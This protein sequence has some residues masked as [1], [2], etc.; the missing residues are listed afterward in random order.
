MAERERK[1]SAIP[2]GAKARVDSGFVAAR[3]KPC[4]YTRPDAK[5]FSANCEAV[6][7]VQGGDAASFSAS[8]E[9]KRWLGVFGAT[10]P[11]AEKCGKMPK[12][13]K[14]SP[15]GAK[16]RGH[17]VAFTARINPGPFKTAIF[18]ASCEVVPFQKQVTA[19]SYRA[20][21]RR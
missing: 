5:S 2:S 7:V 17:F 8:C 6:P 20:T 11:L 18:S 9:A 21:R 14:N 4:P 19:V 15:S 1:S 13:E 16:A 3:L 10:E 12:L